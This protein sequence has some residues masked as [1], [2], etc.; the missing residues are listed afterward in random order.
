MK[1]FIRFFTSCR[2]RG[3][4]RRVFFE[5]IL[6]ELKV[7]VGPFSGIKGDSTSFEYSC[8]NLARHY[9]F[10]PI[11]KVFRMDIGTSFSKFHEQSYESLAIEI[12]RISTILHMFLKR[13]GMY[14]VSVVATEN[15]KT[16]EFSYEASF[17]S[18]K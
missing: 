8:R 1:N 17:P 3:H 4:K 13:N 6:H 11:D 15:G 14:E 2:W 12:R 9:D 16:V 10:Y 7:A 18:K 5:S